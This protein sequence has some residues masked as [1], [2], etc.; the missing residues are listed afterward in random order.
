MLLL[1]ANKQVFQVQYLHN[2]AGSTN[3]AKFAKAA[4]E[5]LI[6]AAIAEASR[7]RKSTTPA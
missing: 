3:A 5:A 6:S 4:A 2:T 7:R 1:A